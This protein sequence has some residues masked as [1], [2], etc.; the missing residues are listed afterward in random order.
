MSRLRRRG[1]AG[2]TIIELLMVVVVGSIVLIPLFGL[3]NMT[4]LRRQPT[5]D[6]ADA[7]R[8]MRLFRNT[9]ADD[10]TEGRVIRVNAPD[11]V[12]FELNCNGTVNASSIKIAIRKSESDRRVLYKLVATSDPTKGPYQLIRSE[13]QHKQ[14]GATGVGIGVLWGFG[15]NLNIPEQTIASKVTE[16]RLPA[17][18]NPDYEP[19]TPCDMN[20]TL[21]TANGDTTTLRLHQYVGRRS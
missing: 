5:N 2:M 9:L 20:V 15:T 12:G 11:P 16:L 8:Q 4:L 1:Q 13:C 21:K 3:L 18:C 14:A 7:A 6:A 10:W 19:F 17:T